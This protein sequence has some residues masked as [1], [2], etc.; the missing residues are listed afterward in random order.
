M[1]LWLDLLAGALPPPPVMI[2][3]LFLRHRLGDGHVVDY[4]DHAIDVFRQ[5]GDESF[6]RVIFSHAAQGHDAVRRGNRGL[7]GAGRTVREQGRLDLRR[8]GRV[9]NLVAEGRVRGRRRGNRHFFFYTF[10]FVFVFF[11]FFCL[12]FFFLSV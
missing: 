1:I 9:I 4:A 2:D 12:F 7:Q 5:F 10:F 6:F 8:N 3:P 11:V